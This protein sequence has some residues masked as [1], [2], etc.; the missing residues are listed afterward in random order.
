MSLSHRCRFVALTLTLWIVFSGPAGT[1]MAWAQ[2]LATEAGGELVRSE[3]FLSWM[4]RA[5]GSI[6]VVIVAM[7][8]YLIALV[9]WMAFHYRASV[10]MPKALVRDVTNLLGQKQYQEA[11]QRLSL[12]SSFLA[13]VVGGRG[14]GKLPSGLARLTGAM[15]L[16]NDA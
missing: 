11:Y 3:S 10:A 9:V 15:E 5:S 1:A 12:D 4:V 16:A 6:G 8:F 2:E 7:S 13:K 14:S